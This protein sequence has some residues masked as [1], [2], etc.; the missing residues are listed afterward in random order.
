MKSN[1]ELFELRAQKA[2]SKGQHEKAAK[3]RVRAEK[4]TQ[5][6]KRWEK[7]EVPQDYRNLFKVTVVENIAT[8]GFGTTRYAKYRWMVM[9]IET[10]RPLKIG[11]AADIKSGYFAGDLWIN[12]QY[13]KHLD[14]DVA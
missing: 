8:A 11:Y 13:Q 1:A 4:W 2:E 3:F 12:R 6:S 7:P 10:D 14:D 9:E 5:R